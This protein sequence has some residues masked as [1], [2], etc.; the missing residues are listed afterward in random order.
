MTWIMQAWNTQSNTDL[1]LSGP[2]GQVY[3]LVAINDMLF[4]GTQVAVYMASGMHFIF[5]LPWY[6]YCPLL[7]SFLQFIFFRFLL[8]V[9]LYVSLM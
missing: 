5:I 6:F 2:V 4:A 9:Y 8:H 3:A 1:S 7:S